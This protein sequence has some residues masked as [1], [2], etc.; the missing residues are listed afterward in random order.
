MKFTEIQHETQQ[1]LHQPF[2]PSGTGIITGTLIIVSLSLIFRE[3]N[4]L[5][6]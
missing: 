3:V 5:K 6:V 4:N 2:D 1:S